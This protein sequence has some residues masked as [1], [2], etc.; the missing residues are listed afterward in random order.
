MSESEPGAPFAL[1]AL[2]RPARGRLEGTERV[3]GRAARAFN[4]RRP[5]GKLGKRIWTT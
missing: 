5:Y 3:E 2:M 1:K 4:V